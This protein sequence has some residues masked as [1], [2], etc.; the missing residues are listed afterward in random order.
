MESFEEE[1]RNRQWWSPRSCCWSWNNLLAHI[2]HPPRFG[3]PEMR[4]YWWSGNATRRTIVGGQG[5]GTQPS[6]QGSSLRNTILS[7]R[8]VNWEFNPHAKQCLA[9]IGILVVT[10]LDWTGRAALVVSRA[11]WTLQRADGLSSP[12]VDGDIQLYCRLSLFRPK[13]KLTLQGFQSPH[14][15]QHKLQLQCKDI[16][17]RPQPRSIRRNAG[18]AGG[19]YVAATGV[20]DTLRQVRTNRNLVMK[21][22]CCLGE[23]LCVASLE[24]IGLENRA[25]LDCPV[26]PVRVNRASVLHRNCSWTIAVQSPRVPE[27]CRIGMNEA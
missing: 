15:L 24:H 7:S 5:S 21:R 14:R 27:Q 6:K 19:T 3:G 20:R 23:Y 10:G 11:V 8:Q 25:L 1:L 4:F 12:P 2:P 9:L 13:M 22:R 18:D 16:H 26:F 17:S